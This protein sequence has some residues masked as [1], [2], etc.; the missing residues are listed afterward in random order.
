[1]INSIGA[2]KS[3]NNAKHDFMIKTLSKMCLEGSI[4][5]I[6][7][8]DDPIASIILNGEKLE[9]FQLRCGTTQGCLLLPLLFNTVAEILS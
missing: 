8:Y 9:A 6:N 7:V 2:E 5:Y 4:L 1:M 3:F